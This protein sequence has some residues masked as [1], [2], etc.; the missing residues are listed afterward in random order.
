VRNKTKHTSVVTARFTGFT[1][2]S[3][4][5]GFNGLFRALPGERIRLV[6]VVS[7]LR[8]CQTRSG[9]L[10]SADLTPATGART[11]RLCRTRKASVVRTPFVRSRG[12][13]RPAIPARARRCRVH[14]IPPRVN[15][16][17]QR[18]FGGRDGEGYRSD[19]GQAGTEIFSQKGLDRANQLE[20]FQQ[21]RR[22]AQWPF[23]LSGIRQA[24]SSQCSGVES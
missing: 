11:T 9:R 1:R 2:H 15:D 10:A 19:L 21:I 13:S 17:G 7:G 18:P 5:N 3:L 16:D 22:R 20:P 8:F 12:S 4:R 23:C 6:T 24:G 14:R